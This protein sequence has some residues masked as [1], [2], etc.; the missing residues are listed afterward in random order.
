[1][2]IESSDIEDNAKGP[3]RMTTEEGSVQE[4]SVDELIKADNHT[5]AAAATAVPYGLR[6]ARIKF[7]GTI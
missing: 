7:P 1:M 3:S 2:T 4:K 5:K 6:L